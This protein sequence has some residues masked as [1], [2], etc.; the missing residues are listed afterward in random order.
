MNQ[1][2]KKQKITAFQVITFIIS[3]INLIL[4]SMLA[5]G[6][7]HLQSTTRKAI[8]T[9]SNTHVMNGERI[10]CLE[11]SKEDCKKVEQQTEV[12]NTNNQ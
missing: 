12:S 2:S 4:F 9:S 11:G 10:S 6:L 8:I 3:I 7:N 5:Y 1:N